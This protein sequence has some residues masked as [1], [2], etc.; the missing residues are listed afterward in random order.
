MRLCLIGK[1]I[2]HSLSPQV[3]AKIAQ[4]NGR[5]VNFELAEVDNLREF[6]CKTV[7]HYDGVAVTSPYK[8]EIYQYGDL[9]SQEV[10]SLKC[11]NTVKINGHRFELYNTDVI[12]F[13]KS[14]APFFKKG[15]RVTI[16][17]NGGAAQSVIWA[18]LNLGAA[19]WD[20]S[21]FNSLEIRSEFNQE[22]ITESQVIIN[23][24]PVGG[25]SSP[26]E[27]PISADKFKSCRVA[28]DLN[29]VPSETGFLRSARLAGVEERKNGFEML[30]LQ[31]EEQQKIWFDGK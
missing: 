21:A 28:F 17:G 25:P 12:G 14:F 11:S 4:K 10:S 31:A 9:L 26:E 1:N 29:Y 2:Q 6:M 15:D 19:T 24:S 5:S 22:W 18:L 3:H 20:Y 23:C 30:R 7:W 13:Q 8:K 27:S 16:I